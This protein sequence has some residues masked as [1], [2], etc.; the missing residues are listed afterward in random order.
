[1]QMPATYHTMSRR[2]QR[3]VGALAVTSLLLLA[4]SIVVL[5]LNRSVIFE[6]R[7]SANQM[8]A[9]SAHEIAEA[10][11]EWAIGMFNRGNPINA[12]CNL[13]TTSST[14]FRSRYVVFPTDSNGV[15]VTAKD[16]PIYP[17]ALPGCSVEIDPANDA[18]NS[19]TCDCPATGTAEVGLGSGA[20]HFTVRFEP[21]QDSQD[22]TD[23][24]KFDWETVRITAIGCI[25]ATNA[26][27]P[28][29]RGVAAET[30]GADA[31]AITSVAV[32]LRPPM[33]GGAF[34]ALSCGGGCNVG[35]S[36][37][38][39]N[40]SVA[41]NGIL[42]A[43]GG[44]IT[45]N[46]GTRYQTIPGLPIENALI[47]HD[48]AMRE[49]AESDPDC[50]KSAMFQNYFGSTIDE[51]RN[52]P[53]T[54]VIQCSTAKDCGTQTLQAYKEGARTFY[55]GHKDNPALDPQWGVSF[56]SSSG[57]P[58]G[59]LG[60]ANDPIILVTSG[61]FNI[62]GNI[63]VNG[64]IYSNSANVNDLGTGTADITGAIITCNDHQNNGGGKLTYSDVVMGYLNRTTGALVKVPGSW[65]DWSQP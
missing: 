29:G 48:Q 40:T 34:A 2:R 24:T 41:A 56:N 47:K 12:A 46:P 35:G 61:A 7:T 17:N 58:G 53:T 11:L 33:V 13:D 14:S 18:G 64:V 32:K 9:A 44:D 37:D 26:C 42:I 30:T 39:V 50:S 27:T 3:G 36:Y 1:M 6:Q 5:Y 19:L 20:P 49:L 52:A 45:R 38:I 10:G 59:A 15:P 22:P 25:A 54:K 28:P 55:Y 57:F 60:S 31:V 62:N 16:A 8:R 51:Y 4:A 23:S 65:R 21:E 43:A 63:T